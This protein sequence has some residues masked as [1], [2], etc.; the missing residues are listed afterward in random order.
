MLTTLCAVARVTGAVTLTGLSAASAFAQRPTANTL[1]L[2]VFLTIDQLRADY[3]DRFLPQ[4][5]GGL[6]RIYRAGAV[7]TNGVQDHAITETAPGHATVLSG[8][9]PWSTGIVANAGVPGDDAGR[10]ERSTSGPKG[11][12]ATGS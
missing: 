10:S 7:F 6:G 9:E 3:F 5:S 2:V 8:R 11:H 4:L 12:A 1:T